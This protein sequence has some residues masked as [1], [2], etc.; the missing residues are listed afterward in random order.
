MRKKLAILGSTGFIGS[1]TLKIARHLN[2]PV[3]A[4][5]A[6]SNIDLLE[7]QAREFKPEL[8]AVYEEGPARALRKRLPE[9]RVV[10][11][12]DGL[13]E[14][15]GF[16][17]FAM[18]AMSGS[19]GILPAIA[20]IEAGKQIGLAN[21]EVMISA[22]ELISNLAKKNGV[23]I[24]PVDSEHSALFQCLKG[25]R[26]EEVRRLILTASGGPFFHK[27]KEELERVTLD[28]ALAHPNFRMGPKVTVDCSTLMNKGLEM[29]EAKWLYGVDPKRVEAVIHPQQRIQSCVEF[30]DGVVMALVSE[31]DMLIPI[32]YAITYPQR[33][34]GVLPPYDF[35]KNGTLTFFP[36]DKQKFRCFGLAIDA[37]LAGKSY[38]C[39]LNAANE[40]LVDRFLKKKI[41]WIEIGE[42]LEKLISSHDP[43]NLLTLEAILE[44]DAKAREIA[45]VV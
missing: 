6:K 20:A 30:I 42:K 40:V 31:P 45:S 34:E 41:S 24:I 9:V 44:V 13:R 10:S 23:E 3:A 43:Q 5:A 15:A 32:Q 16:G 22:G 18:L 12:M 17:D 2:L 25:G 27:T 33:M 21:K 19:L 39:F 29:I 28:E 8:V 35:I 37:M 14:A 26:K 7:A 38:P 1:A 4:L 11:G 36:P